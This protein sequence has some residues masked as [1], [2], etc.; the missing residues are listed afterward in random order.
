MTFTGTLSLHDARVQTAS[1]T[2][3]CLSVAFLAHGEQQPA[4]VVDGIQA[5]S[6]L[7]RTISASGFADFRHDRPD[8]DG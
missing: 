4:A 8:R 6:L 1:V 7:D 5:D 2:L 3:L